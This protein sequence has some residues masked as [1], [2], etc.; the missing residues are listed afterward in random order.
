MEEDL[1]RIEGARRNASER[2]VKLEATEIKRL[3]SIKLIEAARVPEKPWRPD[4]LRDGLINLAAS[5]LLGLFAMWFV[6]LFN[7]SPSPP[8]VGPTTVVMPQPW[9]QPTVGAPESFPSLTFEPARAAVP[10]LSDQWRLPRELNQDELGALLA[11][12]DGEVR[13]WCATLL[14]GL[15]VDELKAMRVKDLDHASLQLTVRGTTTRRLVLP[16]WLAQL[17]KE[18]AGDDPEQPLLC[19][20]SGQMPE[21]SEIIFGI[22]CAALDA[23]LDDAAS[24]SPEALRH[25]YIASVMHQ[26]VR[27]SDLPP[28]VGHLSKEELSAYAAAVT[29]GPRQVRAQ[30]IDT[31][32]P[33]LQELHVG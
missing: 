20:S 17:L 30:K 3:P 12:A 7:R 4:Y 23:G 13:L 9:L 19:N 28:L 25:T 24:V 22:T 2:L 33:A 6:E 10:Q 16:A 29:P 32:M 18:Q 21:T 11:A 1:V 31:L 15:T 27:F 5:F 14:L 26:N 8:P